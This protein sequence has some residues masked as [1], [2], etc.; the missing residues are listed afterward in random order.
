MAGPGGRED[1]IFGGR[2]LDRFEKRDEEW[3]IAQRRVLMDYFQ[4]QPAARDLG[5]FGALPVTGGHY[6]SDP[7]YESA[8]SG[9]APGPE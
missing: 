7:L 4:H 9:A 3:R 1:V 2:Y 5:A 8:A 6:P